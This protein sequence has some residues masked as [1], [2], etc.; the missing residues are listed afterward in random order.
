[1]SVDIKC[2]VNAKPAPKVIFW[3]DHDGRIPVILGNNYRMK[4]DNDTEV[5]DASRRTRIWHTPFLFPFRFSPVFFSLSPHFMSILFFISF[6]L[7][8]V[9]SPRLFDGVFMNAPLRELINLSNQSKCVPSRV[10]HRANWFSFIPSQKC[11]MNRFSRLLFP[12]CFFF[13]LAFDF[14]TWDAS[15]ETTSQEIIS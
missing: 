5:R 15:C 14:S 12:R 3:R 10:R 6:V 4:I 13:L 9:C 8:F 7:G 1:M 11:Q 2:T